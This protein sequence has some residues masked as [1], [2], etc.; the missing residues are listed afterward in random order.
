MNLLLADIDAYLL[1]ACPPRDSILAEM[2]S[3]AAVESFPIVGPLVGRL[4]FLLARISGAKRVLELGSGFGYSGYWFGSAV[5]PGGELTLTDFSSRNLRDAESYFKRGGISCR[6]RFR[7]GNALRTLGQVSGPFD[8]IFNDM[9]KARYPQVF[10]RASNLLR[11]GGLLISDN[12]LSQGRILESGADENVRGILEYTR[13]IFD[14][15]EYFSTVIPIR[16][17][18]SVSVKKSE[19]G[20]ASR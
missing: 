5:G 4:L 19:E 14:S 2:E 8:I 3:R 11:P 20:R 13:L 7:E 12:L 1:Q 10:S 9:D 15:E 16:D 6:T 18:V 17:G